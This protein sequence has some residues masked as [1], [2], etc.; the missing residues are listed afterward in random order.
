M[1]RNCFSKFSEAIKMVGF[2]QSHLD[3]SLFV[4]EKGSTLTMVLIYMDDMIIIGN[5]DKV[6]QDIKFFLQNIFYIT[7]LG[8]LKYF[9]SLVV[10]RSKAGIVISQ[11]KNSP[12]IL[13]DVGLFGAK[14][15]DLPTEQ[16]LRLRNVQGEL[17]NDASH[18]RRLMGRLIYLTITRPD[19]MYY[20]NILSH[21]M[22]AL[23]KPYWDVVFHIMRYL[24]NN[25]GLGLLFSS[26]NSLQLWLIVMQIRQ[27]IL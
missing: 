21:F 16:N 11:R 12:K 19:I 10:A 15:I 18:Y 4:Q 27:I 25:L 8:N 14:P 7:Y 13:D 9:L 24:K 17:L 26:N 23:R 22:H 20:V 2:S 3:H 5:N 6:I 1:P